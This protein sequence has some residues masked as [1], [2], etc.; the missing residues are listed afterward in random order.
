VLGW[1]T[2]IPRTALLVSILQF[3]LSSFGQVPMCKPRTDRNVAIEPQCWSRS[4]AT[5]E[6]ETI[7]VTLPLSAV[8]GLE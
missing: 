7:R 1:L 3:A 8:P 4:K 5:L 6:K 2:M